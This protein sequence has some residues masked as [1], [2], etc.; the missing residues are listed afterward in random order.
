MEIHI[1]MNKLKKIRKQINNLDDTILKLINSRGKLALKI[2]GIKRKEKNEAHLFRPERQAEIIKRL[3]KKKGNIIS[4]SDIFNLWK[5]IFFIQTKMQGEVEYLYTTSIKVKDKEEA[6]IFFGDEVKLKKVSSIKAGFSYIKNKQNSILLLKYPNKDIK[7]QWL[8]TLVNRSLY[9][10]ASIPL[11]LRNDDKP[12]L[13]IVSKNK[14]IA[15]GENIFLYLSVRK[16]KK[17]GVKLLYSKR[18]IFVYQSTSLIKSKDL[19]YLGAF[20]LNIIRN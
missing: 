10:V 15:E 5:T 20:P 9:V 13:L 6:K 4:G 17:N 2:G 16:T 8:H 19:K 18:N 14:P 12:Q 3:I 7:T 1:R 11:I